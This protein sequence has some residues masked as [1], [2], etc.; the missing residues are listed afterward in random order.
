MHAIEC[1]LILFCRLDAEKKAEAERKKEIERKKQEAEK[2][3]E[4]KRL[5]VRGYFAYTYYIIS[6]F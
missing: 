6:A 2:K 1:L 5:S 3:R 4:Q